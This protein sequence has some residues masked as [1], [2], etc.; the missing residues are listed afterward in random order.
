LEKEPIHASASI[1]SNK[2]IN[3]THQKQRRDKKVTTRRNSAGRLNVLNQKYDKLLEKGAWDKTVQS[4]IL[5]LAFDLRCPVKP[6]D[7]AFNR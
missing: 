1:S 7:R 4:I 3:Q 6:S 2:R 5:C